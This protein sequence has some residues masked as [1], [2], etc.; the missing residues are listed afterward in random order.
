MIYLVSG[1]MQSPCLRGV[2]KQHSGTLIW[3]MREG[4]IDCS[5]RA[6]ERL[7]VMEDCML[8]EL[9][10]LRT[11]GWHSNAPHGF[12]KNATPRISA[13]PDVAGLDARGSEVGVVL[14]N[15]RRLEK[16]YGRF[17]GVD[18]TWK[19]LSVLKPRGILA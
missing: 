9:G 15:A 1:A 8:A 11:S 10:L 16:A 12:L 3:F 18:L 4:A 5:Y 17:W 7:L 6:P 13:T 2:R 19:A 14:Q